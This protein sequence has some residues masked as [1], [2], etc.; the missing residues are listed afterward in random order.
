MDK[1]KAAWLSAPVP[2]AEDAPQLGKDYLVSDQ[3]VPVRDGTK[4]GVRFYKLI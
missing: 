1:F 2:L 4:V 3:Q